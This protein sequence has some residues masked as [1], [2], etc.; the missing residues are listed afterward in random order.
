M[1]NNSTSSRD[2]KAAIAEAVSSFLTRFRV[3]LLIV[4]G[5]LIVLVVAVF[6]YFEIRDNRAAAAA[7]ALASVEDVYESWQE[8]EDSVQ[9]EIEEE[10]VNEI[11]SLITS[12]PGT[13]AA[14]RATF[15]RG[16]LNWQ[17]EEWTSAAQ[18]YERVTNEHSTTHLAPIALYNAASAHEEAGGVPA[19]ID[20][21][22]R[23]SDEYSDAPE[24][25][26]ALFALGRLH[27]TREE[28]GRAAEQYRHLV[29]DH[30][31]SN[32]TNLARD[33]II[34]LTSEGFIEDE[35]S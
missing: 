23:L 16:E 5:G 35:T 32:W 10:F 14:A 18:W 28:Y 33:R 15:L 1:S 8:A 19:A 26:R 22:A 9:Q 2:R 20:A 3:P 27:E 6:V 12:Y 25:P 7:E 17:K 11:D 29:E 24:L 21:L 31:A 34:F 13:Y 4:L 30:G